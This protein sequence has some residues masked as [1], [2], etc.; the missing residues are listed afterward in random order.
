MKALASVVCAAT[1]V[2]ATAAQADVYFDTITGQTLV[3]AFGNA[4]NNQL[5]GG[6]FHASGDHAGFAVSLLLSKD[7]DMGGSFSIG[8]A[9]D[10][11]TGSS[12][13]ASAPDLTRISWFATVADSAIGDTADL[14]DATRASFVYSFTAHNPF[15]N[16]STFN[17]EYWVLISST[18]ATPATPSLVEWYMNA[19][20]GGVGTAGQAIY[21]N[22]G[23]QGGGN[24]F[25]PPL[26]SGVVQDTVASLAMTVTDVP[27]PASLAL[28]TGGLAG[29][30]ALRRRGASPAS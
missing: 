13:V 25:D 14:N 18:H 6:S 28:L 11:G 26:P 27:E 7:T 19:G 3:D 24:Y 4:Y 1:L 20:A 5:F 29:L 10:Q 23:N 15:T 21:S 30:G 12:G 16:S 8:L 17:D 22:S 9:P 2:C